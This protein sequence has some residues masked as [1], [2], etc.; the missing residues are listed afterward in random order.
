M[1]AQVL[2][3]QGCTSGAGKSALVMALDDAAVTG[4][5]I[6]AGGL[7]LARPLAWLDGCPDDALAADGQVAGSY[8]HG[9][10]DTPAAAEALLAWAGL[11]TAQA[12]DIHAL[13]ET[14][15]DRLADAVETHL[16]LPRPR[17]LPEAA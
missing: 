14:A 4:Y 13:R 16:D 3:V 6:H 8:L 10:F 12:P 15:I 5:E 7:A 9:L 11:R 2:M 17:S 1:S